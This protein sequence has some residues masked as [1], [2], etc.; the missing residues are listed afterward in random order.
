MNTRTKYHRDGTI[1][2]WSVYHQVWI[3][4]V[5]YIPD[6]ELAARNE[7]ERARIIRHM[8]R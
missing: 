5:D 7:H 4:H 2:Y 3:E 6:E 1:T 8:A